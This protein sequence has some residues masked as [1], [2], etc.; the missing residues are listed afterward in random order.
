MRCMGCY[1][2]PGVPGCRRTV[3][4]IYIRF[5]YSFAMDISFIILGIL[6]AEIS[7][8]FWIFRWAH[9]ALGKFSASLVALLTTDTPEREAIV[10]SI[11]KEMWKKLN[12]SLNRNQIERSQEGIG[13]FIDSKL[14]QSD[15]SSDDYVA[16][17]PTIPAGIP[18]DLV[19]K[20]LS[21][22]LKGDDVIKYAPLL[23]S[24]ASGSSNNDQSGSGRW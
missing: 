6:I 2:R 22:Q 12:A 7:M 3:R 24:L 10:A 23:K 9:R 8:V 16:P 19:Q 5:L 1:A 4:I 14:N 21:G 15:D 11:A 20:F 17:K 18:A 13:N